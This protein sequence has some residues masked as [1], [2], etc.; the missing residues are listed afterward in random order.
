MI[1][2]NQLRRM[3]G[4]PASLNLIVRHRISIRSTLVITRWSKRVL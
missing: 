2:I 4:H 3:S 1:G